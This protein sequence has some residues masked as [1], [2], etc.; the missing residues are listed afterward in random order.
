VYIAHRDANQPEQ[1]AEALRGYLEKVPNVDNRAQLEARLAA[2]D[3]GLAREREREAEAA[4]AAAAAAEQEVAAAPPETAEPAPQDP[5]RWWLTPTVVLAAGG[6]LMAASIPTGVL[7]NNKAKELERECVNGL[8]DPG[9]KATRDSG[10]TMAVVTDVLLFTGAAVAV[11]GA[12]LMILKRPKEARE[13]A[14]L[15]PSVACG[16]RTCG[17][18]LTVKF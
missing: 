2:L 8:C 17:G 4:A 9:A 7:A 1:A 12:V 13:S 11:T 10:H 3:A 6:A 5:G 16:P 14:R 15:Q 18:S